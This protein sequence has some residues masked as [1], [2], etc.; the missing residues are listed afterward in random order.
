MLQAWAALSQMYGLKFLDQF[1][2][3]PPQMW[4]A[5]FAKLGAQAVRAGIDRLHDSGSKFA[6]TLPEFVE[7]C[8]KW[9]GKYHGQKPAPESQQI[10][11]KS[12][13]ERYDAALKN[14]LEICQDAEATTHERHDAYVKMRNTK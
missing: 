4:T 2:D 10:V 9:D 5:A 12:T 1:G 6:P 11:D 3:K 8:N 7:A 14:Y 13:N